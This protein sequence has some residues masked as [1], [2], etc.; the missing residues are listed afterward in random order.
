MVNAVLTVTLA[1]DTL[2]SRTDSADVEHIGA[3]SR[4]TCCT[5]EAW[6]GGTGTLGPRRSWAVT[7][8]QPAERVCIVS[9]HQLPCFLPSVVTTGALLRAGVA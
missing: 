7:G 9:Q 3:L 8:V 5:G 2:H 6:Q 4:G 1:E